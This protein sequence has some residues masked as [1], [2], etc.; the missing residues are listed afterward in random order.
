MPQ[1]VFPQQVIPEDDRLTVIAVAA[2]AC[3][4]QNVLHEGVGHGFASYLQGAHTITLSTVAEDSDVTSRWIDAAGT[5]VNL[6]AAAVVYLALRVLRSGPALRLFLILCLAG[7]LF[8]GTGYFLFSGVFG[9][10]DWQQVIR[11]LEPAWLWRLGLVLVGVA[12]Y[13]AA[14]RLVAS[15][16][17]EFARGTLPRRIRTLAW[18]PYVVAGVLAFVAGLRN[19]AGIFFVFAS[20]LPSTLGANAGLWNMPGMVRK[21]LPGPGVGRIERNWVWIAAGSLAAAWFILILGR[22]ITWHR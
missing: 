11:G 9:F 2:L 7:N 22:G 15:E 10:G 1:N 18:L 20:A 21:D 16:F 3:M 19:P 13:V 17:T 6:A 4:L 12:S 8:T 14:V 5:L